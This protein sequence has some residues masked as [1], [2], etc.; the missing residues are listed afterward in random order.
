M[1]KESASHHCYT[2]SARTWLAALLLRREEL[3]VRFAAHYTVLAKRPRAWRRQITKR[4]T[5]TLTGAALLLALTGSVITAELDAPTSTITVVNGEVNIAANNKC[6]LIEAILNANNKVNG[7]PHTD[8][9]AG[10][11]NGADTISLPPGGLFNLTK[12]HNEGSSGANGLPWINT[13]ITIN[14]KGA[15]I[16][17]SDIAPDFR[18]LAVGP[19][20]SL[21]LNN[22]TI[23]NGSLNFG[24]TN[25]G[26]AGILN[27]GLLIISDSVIADNFAINYYDTYSSAHGGG[28]ENQGILTITG[29][30]VRDNKVSASDWAFGGGLYNGVDGSASLHNSIISGNIVSGYEADGGGGGNVGS[31]AVTGTS[32]V[33]NQAIGT[34][35]VYGGAL[36]SQNQATIFSTTFTDN[37]TQGGRYSTFLGATVVN[38]YF[39]FMNITN[40]TIS[41]N[42]GDGLA[43]YNDATL[44]NITITG[45]QGDGV[46]SDCGY[47][48]TITRFNMSLVTGNDG[49]EV[50]IDDEDYC[51]DGFQANRYN[52]F[53][54]SG[55][56]GLINLTPGPT[57][58]IPMVSVNSILLPLSDNGGLTYTHALAADSPALDRAP[59]N[60]CT[61]TPVNGVDQRGLPRNRNGKGAISPNECDIGAFE[62][63]PNVP[64]PTATVT[65]LPTPTHTPTATVS[66]PGPSATS[67]VTATSTAT[68]TQGP[69]P[70]PTATTPSE[71]PTATMDPS[72]TPANP[73]LTIYLPLII[74]D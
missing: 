56:A 66:P 41:N 35:Y 59:N 36:F 67:T 57:D 47:H 11:P 24:P 12:I 49:W 2:V 23:R 33:K 22:A 29:T 52:I 10:N 9:S 44:T 31:L 45:N 38:G 27:Q 17:R 28:I 5:A 70:T 72:P 51:P 16:Q 62:F 37:T 69:S 42:E 71:M 14:G 64:K 60:A 68:A 46:L 6:S 39:G 43:N 25:N 8:C 50:Y 1:S 61:I 48:D 34:G 63:Q 13:P 73:D 53:G 32:F 40:S 7:Q 4:L 54:D 65:L 20:G 19:Q 74:R 55:D 58:I 3:W 30:T 21:T 26:G 18:I 15:T